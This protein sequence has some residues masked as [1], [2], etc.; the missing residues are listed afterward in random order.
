MKEVEKVKTTW[1]GGGYTNKPI[2]YISLIID[3]ARSYRNNS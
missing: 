3:V 1:E 2:K